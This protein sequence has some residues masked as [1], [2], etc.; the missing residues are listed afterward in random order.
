[1]RPAR[2]PCRM[3]CGGRASRGLGALG[4]LDGVDR[5]ERTT[6]FCLCAPTLA[7]PL[8]CLM[9]CA[10]P[11]SDVGDRR[12]LASSFRVGGRKNELQSAVGSQFLAD[13]GMV[14]A[15]GQ[16]SQ[17]FPGE[18][19]ITPAAQI[20]KYSLGFVSLRNDH[21]CLVSLARVRHADF[22]TKTCSIRNLTVCIV[23]SGFGLRF[24]RRV[25]SSSARCDFDFV[26]AVR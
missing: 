6:A 12:R 11:D 5:R 17:R 21:L 20:E 19:P 1:M 24:W 16:Q 25:G 13:L 4:W 10:S 3:S 15:V 22:N 8:C 23:R 7:R 26:G 2:P 18:T 14:I 9:F